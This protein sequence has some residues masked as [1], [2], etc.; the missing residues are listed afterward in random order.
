MAWV[1]VLLGATY[2]IAAEV[3]V[4]TTLLML[5]ASGAIGYTYR[6]IT[7]PEPPGAPFLE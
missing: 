3:A 4:E 1:P 6:T 7:T 5:G 2:V